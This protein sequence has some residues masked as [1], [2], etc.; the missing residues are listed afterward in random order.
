MF[1]VFPADFRYK[2]D[3][4]SEQKEAI[5]E[6]VKKQQHYSVTPEVKREIINSKSRGEVTMEEED[7]D[8][9]FGYISD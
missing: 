5:V 8:L 6:L 9:D 4:T 2:E 1:C 7:I 3:I